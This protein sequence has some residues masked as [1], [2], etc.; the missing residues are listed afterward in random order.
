MAAAWAY[1]PLARPRPLTRSTGGDIMFFNRSVH[2]A[3]TLASAVGRVLDFLITLTLMALLAIVASQ[4]I[5]RNFITLWRESPE[6]YVKIGLVWLCFIGIVRA[7]VAYETIRITFLHEKLP[8]YLQR[9]L[10]I[11]LDILVLVV[12]GL[13]SWK[14]YVLLDS[15]GMQII[16]GTSLS[17]DAPVY[18]M[19]IG[20]TL[21]W[22][23]IAWRFGMTLAGHDM[24]MPHKTHED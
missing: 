7:A 9:P 17:L 4:V 13:L 10:D 3:L 15:A 12:L 24:S 2:Y 16:L 14:S 5:D 20:F 1:V 23:V 21:L 22:V 18:G 6:E 8:P 19:L 11:V